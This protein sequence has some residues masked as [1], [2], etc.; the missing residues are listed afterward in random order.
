M[1][2]IFFDTWDTLLRT[3]ILAVSAYAALVMLV[4]ISG[5]RT[6]SKMNTFDFVVTVALGSTL[7]TV[8]LSKDTSLVQGVLAF[9]VLIGCQFAVSWSCVRW[10]WVHRWVTGEPQML[11]Y[12]GE[13][14]DSAMKKS[15]VTEEDVLAAIRAAGLND[16]TRVQ[17]VVLETDASLSVIETQA[18]GPHATLQAMRPEQ[19]GAR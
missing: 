16:R 19:N 6:L 3:T 17:A 2:S 8:V 11:L 10:R 9:G 13:Y 14:I 12:Q 18:N 4:R 15:R 5:K 7:A 1:G